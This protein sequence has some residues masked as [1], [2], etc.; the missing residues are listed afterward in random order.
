MAALSTAA[1]EFIY[2]NTGDDFIIEQLRVY[3]YFGMLTEFIE[4][5]KYRKTVTANYRISCHCFSS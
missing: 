3:S 1:V 4:N 5:M 2:F